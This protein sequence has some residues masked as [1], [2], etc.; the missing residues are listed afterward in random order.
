MHVS[1]FSRPLPYSAAAPTSGAHDVKETTI[2]EA[3]RSVQRP[4]VRYCGVSPVPAEESGLWR[5]QV[6]VCGHVRALGEFDTPEEAAAA[7]NKAVEW[8]RTEAA[9]SGAAGAGVRAAVAELVLNP[10]D[11][12]AFSTDKH[13]AVF[14]RVSDETEEETK[15]EEAAEEDYEDAGGGEGGG[16]GGGRLNGDEESEVEVP[17]AT[18]AEPALACSAD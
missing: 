15:E 18:S 12:V 3:I 13:A 7:Y 14:A 5:A 1:L 16:A 2:L 10:V 9:G 4:C 6:E 11:G 17:A 8:L